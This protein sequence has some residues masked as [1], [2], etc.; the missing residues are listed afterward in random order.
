MRAHVDHQLARA[1][2]G[3]QRRGH[4]DWADVGP[5]AG[6]VVTAVRRLAADRGVT[7][8]SRS[9]PR[10]PLRRRRRRS[11]GDAGQPARQRHQV[12]AEPR[13]PGLLAGRAAASSSPSTMTG[14]A[15]PTRLASRPSR[16]ARASTRR[17]P[18]TGWASP[19]SAT[20]PSMWWLD[21][22]DPCRTRR[23]GRHS[24]LAVWLAI[25][26]STIVL[27]RI[28]AQ[29]MPLPRYAANHAISGIQRSPFTVAKSPVLSCMQWRMSLRGVCV[30][31]SEGHVA[32]GG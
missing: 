15:C 7:V 22:P 20:S 13:R 32:P 30:R 5:C 25:N 11:R 24:V 31:G 17:S 14:R 4:V 8:D 19:S 16:A 28:A 2:A 3:G 6:G 9:R 12:G 1:R 26:R 18:A 10:P 21:H 27:W 29:I 23:T